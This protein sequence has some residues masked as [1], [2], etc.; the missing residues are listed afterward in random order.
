MVHI[1]PFSFT[2]DATSVGFPT[3]TQSTSNALALTTSR[4][5]D[6]AVVLFQVRRLQSK[7]YQELLMSSREPLE[8]SSPYVWSMLRELQDWFEDLPENPPEHIRN[9]FVLE[10]LY[11]SIYC[12]APS[13]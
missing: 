8:C 13:W 6:M 11:S 7:W 3:T 2:D 12:L 10:F 5:I 9:V 1:R 4:R